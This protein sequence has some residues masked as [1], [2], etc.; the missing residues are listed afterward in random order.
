MDRRDPQ[1]LVA[2]CVDYSIFAGPAP[3]HQT[4]FVRECTAEGS[5]L[6][7]SRAKFSLPL[8]MKRS[9]MTNTRPHAS[10]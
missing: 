7:D 6:C 8:R 2:G 4:R 9:I 3:H 5:V 10:R 1:A